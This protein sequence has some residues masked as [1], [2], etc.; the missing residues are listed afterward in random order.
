MTQRRSLGGARREATERVTLHGPDLDVEAWTLNV[1]RGGLRVIV[2]EM[3]SVGSDY[4]VKFEDGT[5]RDARVVWLREEA[6][7]QIAGLQFLDVPGFDVSA[8]LD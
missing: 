5:R 4:S 8:S 3:L 2:E 6:D 7:G 1:S